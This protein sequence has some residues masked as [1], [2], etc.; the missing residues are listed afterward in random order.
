MKIVIKGV[1]YLWALMDKH[2]MFGRL[3][4]P[5]ERGFSSYHT[6][7]TITYKGGFNEWLFFNNLL[8][9]SCLYRYFKKLVI[10]A[11]T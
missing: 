5:G 9:D 3:L 2:V 7:P 1:A 8:F 6:S 4:C 11:S 10:L